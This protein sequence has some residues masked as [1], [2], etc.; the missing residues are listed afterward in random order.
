M[1]LKKGV[2]TRPFE[3][4][5]GSTPDFFLRI[6]RRTCTWFSVMCGPAS[7][8]RLNNNTLSESITLVATRARHLTHELE[9]GF[10]FCHCFFSTKK[11]ALMRFHA[12]SKFAL[13]GYCVVQCACHIWVRIEYCTVKH[14]NINSWKDMQLDKVRSQECP[15]WMTAHHTSPSLS[16]I[17]VWSIERNIQALPRI[18][19]PNIDL[20]F[21]S[22]VF[23]SSN[24]QNRSSSL[25][26]AFPIQD[27]ASLPHTLCAT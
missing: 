15:A 27:N 9:P 23:I 20:C 18:I 21:V 3:D 12:K 11:K 1:S 17:L 25:S 2:R 5:Q 19:G 4:R 14:P 16:Q 10:G 24:P 13:P 8:R 7:T 26:S 22:F 6:P